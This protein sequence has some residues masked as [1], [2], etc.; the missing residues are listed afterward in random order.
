MV[1]IAFSEQLIGVRERISWIAETS[2]GA[3][4]TMSSGE[5]VGLNARI[6]PD[7][8][9]NWQEILSAGADDR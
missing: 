9:Q 1:K 4:G 8:N 6:E 2:Y 7:F 5:I 3:G